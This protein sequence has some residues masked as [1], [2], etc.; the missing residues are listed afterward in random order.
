MSIEK[1]ALQAVA[2]PG[3][4]WAMPGTSHIHWMA[5]N[6][7]Q[8]LWAERTPNWSMWLLGRLGRL[9][10]SLSRPWQAPVRRCNE[11]QW[12]PFTLM[13]I[14]DFFLRSKKR[15]TL[16]SKSKESS[17]NAIWFSQTPECR[18][19]LKALVLYVFVSLSK[20]LLQSNPLCE[21][22]HWNHS[23]C[24]KQRCWRK[25]STVWLVRTSWTEPKQYNKRPTEKNTT[26]HSPWEPE[27]KHQG[28]WRTPWQQKR[29]T[30]NRWETLRSYS[31]CVFLPKHAKVPKT[32][33]DSELHVLGL[34]SSCRPCTNRHGAPGNH[35]PIQRHSAPAVHQSGLAGMD[36][37]D[38][39]Y[40]IL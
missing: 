29:D 11:M 21:A 25:T 31:Y 30:R 40:N 6:Q 22:Q 3:M 8:P 32:P 39:Y 5:T 18:N 10:E 16:Q 33:N 7:P 24:L 1:H 15:Q 27:I 13:N 35:G 36:C 19:E 4:P 14:D 26:Y 2:P 28:R 17:S 23:S 34:G 38:I 20:S 37:V 9:D 12:D